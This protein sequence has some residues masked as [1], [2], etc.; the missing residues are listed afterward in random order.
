VT[1][2]AAPQMLHSDTTTDTPSITMTLQ[3]PV[4]SFTQPLESVVES[5]LA[6]EAWT[7]E[8]GLLVKLGLTVEA[9]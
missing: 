1:A 6:V 2:S 5:G 4:L 9:S 3:M 7:L 8:P